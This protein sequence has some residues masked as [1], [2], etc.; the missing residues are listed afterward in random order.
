MGTI[1][2]RRKGG[3][4][5]GDWTDATGERHQRSLRTKDAKVARERLRAAELGE[6]T[7][8]PRRRQR[9][10]EA[11]DYVITLMHDKAE[12]T[13]EM[14][15]EKGRRIL[16]TLGD[17]F[18]HEIDRDMLS[19]YIAKRLGDD[20]DHGGAAPH[21]VAKELITIRR[22]L[23]E[24]NERGVLRVMPSVPRFSPR[25]QPRET[26]LTVEQF[27]VLCAE[28]EP[29]RQLWAC[30]AALAG[31]SAGEIER[32]EWTNVEL[33]TQIVTGVPSMPIVVGRVLLPGTKRES[34]R[35]WVPLAPAL[36]HRLAAVAEEK[37][38]GRVVESWG[39]VRRDLHAA[40]ARANRRAAQPMPRVSPNDLRRTFASW[41]VQAGA[42]LLTVATLMGHS[43]TRMVERVYG[44]LSA[45]NLAD[46]IA[47]LPAIGVTPV[48]RA[49]ARSALPPPTPAAS[50][51][52][53]SR[54]GSRR[55]IE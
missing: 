21:T 46:A 14:Y 35:R 24:A 17:P 1:Y 39:N 47:V 7:E 33:D 27:D 15:Q 38:Q 10:S 12:G 11:I 55:E 3:N 45:R 16:T 50:E 20:R 53:R 31:G 23:R 36:R 4:Y 29:K 28:L 22:A 41:L 34:R 44:R 8:A 43:S 18:V 30:L 54:R 32:L 42:P 9:L 40:V 51:T 52:R 37:R 49:P 25:Y 2:Q 19:G 13:R 5:Y 6:A 26:W 48:S